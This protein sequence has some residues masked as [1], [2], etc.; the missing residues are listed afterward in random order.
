M[1]ID[2]RSPFGVTLALLPVVLLTTWSLVVLLVVAWRHGT[3]EDSRLAGWLSV[4]WR[5]RRGGGHALAL[6][7]GRRERGPAAHGAT[8]THTGS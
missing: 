2:L 1:P 4:A 6:A 7:V 5:A 8:S 3:E